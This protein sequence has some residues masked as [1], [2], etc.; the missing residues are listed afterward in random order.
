MMECRKFSRALRTRLVH[1]NVRN[2]IARHDTVGASHCQLSIWLHVPF[3]DVGCPVIFEPIIVRCAILLLVG[4]AGKS[5]V[6]K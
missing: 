3:V 1:Y 2:K 4:E 5:D 6:V